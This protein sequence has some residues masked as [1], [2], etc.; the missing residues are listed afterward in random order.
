MKFAFRR[1]KLPCVAITGDDAYPV[2]R[3]NHFDKIIKAD[4]ARAVHFYDAEGMKFDYRPAMGLIS[5]GFPMQKSTKKQIIEAVFECS[6]M[7]G[8]QGKIRTKTLSNIRLE[9]VLADLCVAIEEV[10][11]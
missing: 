10:T 4:P 7:K 8:H 2:Y 1:P 6:N 5:P 9:E 11:L 3:H